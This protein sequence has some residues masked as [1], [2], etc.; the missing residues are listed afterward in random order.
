MKEKN[1]V[2]QSKAALQREAEVS[3]FPLSSFY[4]CWH[5]GSYIA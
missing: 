4:S 2:R 5:E 1:K 3:G